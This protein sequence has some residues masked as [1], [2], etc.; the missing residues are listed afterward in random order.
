MR[1]IHPTDTPLRFRPLG[2]IC[3]A[4]LMVACGGG[5]DDDPAA[6]PGDGLPEAAATFAGTW[7][8]TR[9]TGNTRARLQADKTGDNQL[10]ATGGVTQYA[11][12]GCTGSVTGNANQG[13]PAA[14]QFEGLIAQDGVQFARGTSGGAAEV[15]GLDTERRLLCRLTGAEASAGTSDST[16]VSRL[17]AKADADECY[18]AFVGNVPGPGPGPGPG[19]DP[20]PGAGAAALVGLYWAPGNGCT[21]TDGGNALPGSQSARGV[22][23]VYAGGNAA[24][25]RIRNQWYEYTG[26]GCTGQATLLNIEGIPVGSADEIVT[27]QPAQRIGGHNAHRFTSASH[28]GSGGVSY[29][30]GVLTTLGGGQLCMAWSSVME[31]SPAPLPD[32]AEA[33]ELMQVITADPARQ[34]MPRIVS[35]TQ[36]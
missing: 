28:N 12:A 9:C 17:K 22:Q 23:G 20:N 8:S 33:A 24:T 29:N 31:P 32:N 19:P 35:P 11:G 7:V 16:L 21:S 10:R 30:A 3:L 4:A 5:G 34:C 15:W 18:Q 13:N 6:P 1:T 2:A 26:P 14:V 27:L 36:M 25:V